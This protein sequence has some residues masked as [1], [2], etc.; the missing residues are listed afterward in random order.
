MDQHTKE[1]RF[2]YSL[3]YSYEGIHG[4]KPFRVDTKSQI[5]MKTLK[6]ALLYRH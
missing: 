3:S 4:T 1:K 5:C 2:A 6:H